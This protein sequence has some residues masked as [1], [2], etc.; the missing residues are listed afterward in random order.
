MMKGERAEIHPFSPSILYYKQHEQALNNQGIEADAMMTFPAIS[1]CNRNDEACRI[2]NK[3][4]L[5][6][7]ASFCYKLSGF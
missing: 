3:K 4:L 6:T 2:V 5:D 7:S 1:H